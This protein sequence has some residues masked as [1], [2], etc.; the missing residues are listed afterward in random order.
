MNAGSK[1]NGSMLLSAIADALGWITEFEKSE[2]DLKKKYD[3]NKIVSF[4]KW[5]KNVGGRFLGYTDY[6]NEGSYSDDTQL[7]LSVARSIDKDGS[8]DHA[9]FAKIELP[10]WLE[11]SRGAGRT[12]KNA[13]RKITRKS[14]KW[15][16]NF[17]T[18]K[19]RKTTVDYRNAGA[20]GAA[21]RILPIALANFGDQQKIKKEIFS[22]SIITHGHPRAI[23]GAQLY[24][25]CINQMLQY[26]PESFNFTNFL[27][28]IG[29]N[30]EDSF[31]LD[32]VNNPDISQWIYRWD[33]GS[34]EPFTEVY[35]KTIIEV[36]DY[37]RAIYQG[38]IKNSK[39]R[40][41]LKYLGCFAPET[42]GSGISTVIA[43]VYLACRFSDE[44]IKGVL[45]AVNSLGSD[46]DSIAAFVGGLLGAL[47]GQSI[48]P[49]NLRIVQDYEYIQSVA[50]TLLKISLGESKEVRNHSSS[51]T[52]SFFDSK[53]IE[54][55]GTLKLPT[56]G[57]G[58]I[59]KVDKQDALTKG[60][61]NLI[62]DV[63]FAIGQSCRFHKLMNKTGFDF[64]IQS[65]SQGG[66]AVLSK[67]ERIDS[68]RT[69]IPPRYRLEFDKLIND[70]TK[71]E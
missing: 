15:N 14:A 3:Q 42:K 54:V 38:L 11:Y 6:L 30:I 40:D 58:K 53:N 45:E 41:V 1:Y 43:G 39:P 25:Y 21:M 51:S 29:K 2:S 13:A 67:Q 46:T 50:K 47:H 18:Y 33:N 5:K 32:F 56:L 35:S 7:L 36:R 71:S 31:S 27:T 23:L 10:T 57:E 70:L 37:L 66:S 26:R 24:G 52:Q 19:I 9:Y 20:N 49:K 64:P 16:S 59:V 44:P 65:I 4:H 34:K 8:V 61:Y 22:N 12:I 55:G 69:K 48:I 28:E 60:K 63:E 17:F 68:F 62:Y